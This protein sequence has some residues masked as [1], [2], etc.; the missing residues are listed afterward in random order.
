MGAKCF[1]AGNLAQAGDRDDAGD[2]AA[3]G[4]P[5]TGYRDIGL[6][7]QA[8]AA[9]EWGAGGKELWLLLRG[10]FGP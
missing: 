8:D 7:E 2:P 3:A 5:V 1:P 4:T 6:Q 9:A 10:T